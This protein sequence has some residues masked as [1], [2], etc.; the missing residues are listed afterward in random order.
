MS[1]RVKTGNNGETAKQRKCNRNKPQLK[2]ENPFDIV[3]N[4]PFA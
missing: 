4:P 3:T 1:E 2:H